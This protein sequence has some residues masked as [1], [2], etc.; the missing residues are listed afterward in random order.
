MRD[1]MGNKTINR[2]VAIYVGA[3]HEALAFHEVGHV[4]FTEK[5][6]RIDES[7]AVGYVP[8]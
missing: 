5:T 8:C 4:Q 6:M 7:I 1:I 3:I 2:A